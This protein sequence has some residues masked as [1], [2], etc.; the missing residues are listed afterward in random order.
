VIGACLRGARVLACITIIRFSTGA[1]SYVL[2]QVKQCLLRTL[3]L[4]IICSA[5]SSQIL[6]ADTRGKTT[7]RFTR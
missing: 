3:D 1:S 7:A 2:N 5:I 6:R 4:I